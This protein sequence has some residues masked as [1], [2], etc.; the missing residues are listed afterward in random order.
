MMRHR[1][2]ATRR[3]GDWRLAFLALVLVLPTNAQNS[4]FI[5]L[6][7]GRNLDG[8]DGDPAVWTVRD[9]ILIGSSDGHPIKQNTFLIYKQPYADFVLQADVKLRNHNSGIQFRSTVLPG[10]GWVVTGYQADFSEAG[11]KSAWGNFYEEKG[12]SRTVMKTPD[13]GWRIGQ[14]VYK[15]LDWNHYEILAQ[16]RRIRLKLNGTVTID[17]TDDKASSGIIAL[18]LHMG[19]PMRVEFKNILL[20]SLAPG[21]RYE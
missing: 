7:N 12:R 3:R 19:E 2:A 4:G 20:K 15:P 11:E 9:G 5:P 21:E 6:F 8:W 10:P 13:E 17:T 16:G 18:Q 1:D 14:K